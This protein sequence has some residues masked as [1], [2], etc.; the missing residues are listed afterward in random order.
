MSRFLRTTDSD[1][2][3]SFNILQSHS[4]NVRQDVD[5]IVSEILKEM[6]LHQ[7]Q[8]LLKYTCQFDHRT[9]IKTIDELIIDSSE[10]EKAFH[11]LPDTQKQALLLMKSRIESFHRRHIP[12][13]DL[14]TDLEGVQLGARWNAIEA[15]GLYVPGGKASYP[16]SVIMNAIPAKVAGVKR[17]VMTVPAPEGHLNPL[18]LAAAFISGV[19]EVYTIGGAQAIAAL[20]YG[21]ETIAPVDKIVG[22]GNAYVASAKK[23]V[24]GYVGI[25]MVAGPSE[26]LI[27]ADENARP[28]WIAMDLL[29]Q[30]EH[31]ETAQSILITPCE[32]LAQRVEHW[33]QEHLKTL[34]RK[35]IAQKSWIDHGAMIITDTLE[36]AASL[37]NQL[38][39]E[40]LEL[41]VQEPDALFRLIRHAGS[42]FLGYYTPEAIGDYIAGPNHVL[43]TSRSARY[44]SGLSV[45]DFMKRTTV[46]NCSLNA[47]GHIGW[48]AIVLA[49][50]EGL[51]A[52]AESVRLR[53]NA[54]D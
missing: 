10:L 50:T 7:D 6:K 49:E 54:E 32:G 36:T 40:H 21:T 11:Q 24:F 53:L 45:L 18:V 48:S 47:L 23:Q 42:V 34:P 20:A 38:A 41:A 12:S 39:P 22:P 30:A 9:N 4:R 8:A 52:H 25:D 29:S 51:H 15:V 27:I 26:I 2:S 44:S 31:D 37:S 3:T 33:V 13:N 19:T 14:Y 16:S 17:L 1:F 5:G 43:P 35:D 46:M 28:D